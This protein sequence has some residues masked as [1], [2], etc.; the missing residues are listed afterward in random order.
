M[1]TDTK[2]M[3][4]QIGEIRTGKQLGFK[5]SHKWIYLPCTQ[6]G[7]PRWVGLRRQVPRFQLC[8]DCGSQGHLTELG[9]KTRFNSERMRGY[10]HSPESRLKMSQKQRGHKVSDEQKIKLMLANLGKKQ[11]P[12]TIAKRVAALKARPHKQRRETSNGYILI[13]APDHPNNYHGLVLEHR[14]VIEKALGRELQ[15]N[16]VVHHINGNTKDNRSENLFVFDGTGSHLK[17]HN[18]LLRENGLKRKSPKQE[19][20]RK[21]NG[22]RG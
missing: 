17:F 5:D 6:C 20:A 19:Q 21:R 13:Y 1:E 12:E 8:Q 18:K 10:K 16:E 7:K 11:S 3:Q 9:I 22:R 14:L 2:V 15:A 4:P